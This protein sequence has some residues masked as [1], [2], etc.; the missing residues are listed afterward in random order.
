MSQNR[1]ICPFFSYST[2]VSLFIPITIRVVF[3]SF[4]F[5]ITTMTR[6][7]LHVKILAST[8]LLACSFSC[9]RETVLPHQA[10]QPNAVAPADDTAF[11]WENATYVPTAPGYNVRMPWASGGGS[12]LDIAVASDYH[13]ND[14]WDMVYN[15]FNNNVNPT[16]P[17]QSP[18]YFALYNRFRGILRYY[19][20]N[21]GYSNYSTQLEHG[22]SLM[23]SSSTSS[24]LNF[25]GNDLADPSNN[26]KG[27]TQTSKVSLNS[28][29]TWY[30]MQY[31]IAY[32]PSYTSQSFEVFHPHWNITNVNITSIKTDGVELGT[33]NG[34]ITTPK[35]GVDWASVAING[36]LAVGE[37]VGTAGVSTAAG[38][39]PSGWQSA[40]TGGLAGSTTGVLSGLFG[41]NSSNSQEVAL[42]IN[43]NITTTG[44][45]SSSGGAVDVNFWLPG[46]TSTTPANAPAQP[47]VNYPIGLFNLSKRPTVVVTAPKGGTVN[48]DVAYA[49]YSLNVDDIKNNLFQTNSTVINS[50]PTG[51]SISNPKFEVVAFDVNSAWSPDGATQTESIGTH[52]VVYTGQTSV[53]FTTTVRRVPFSVASNVGVRVSFWVTPNNGAARTFVVKT[54]QANVVPY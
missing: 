11:D 33:L 8:I 37:F 4:L 36:L 3:I 17:S 52:K 18:L 22:L 25:E 47:I 10:P 46:Q 26:V 49:D 30:V 6:R 43:S 15:T 31:Q 29:S 23:P 16:I 2:T 5:H 44:T 1:L 42:T 9:Q 45:A 12:T 48:N 20:F 24:M 54:F 14:G 13:H 27:F 41:G 21:P 19:Y 50:S 32:D 40:A 39:T 53:D 34:S 35:A 38:A 51:V 7:A 28:S